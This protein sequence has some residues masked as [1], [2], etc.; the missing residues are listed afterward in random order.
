MVGSSSTAVVS[1]P[2]MIDERNVV[3]IPK[4][5]VSIEAAPRPKRLWQVGQKLGV[6][7]EVSDPVS[8]Y[9]QPTIQGRTANDIDGCDLIL[10]ML[11]RQTCRV[12]RDDFLSVS[13]SRC[14]YKEHD[15][16]NA[17]QADPKESA[18]SSEVPPRTR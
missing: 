11:C 14:R 10:E 1:I 3:P 6:D 16:E 9:E 8:V 2:R 15:H 18:D 12:G 4:Q 17:A 5:M 13:L 7:G